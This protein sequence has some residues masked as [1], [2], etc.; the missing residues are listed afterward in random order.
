MDVC[1]FLTEGFETI[2]AFA[3][4]DI[5]R[6]A[7]IKTST[8]SITGNICVTSAQGVKVEADS[9]FD[10]YEFDGSELL[11]L[12]GGP[13]HKSYYQCE[14]LLELIKRYNDKNNRIAAICAAPSVLGNLGLLEGRKAMAFPGFEEQLK[15]AEV[16]M[17]PERVVTDGNI[18]TSRGMGTSID[19][20]LELVRLIKGQELSDKLRKST[21][22]V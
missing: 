15:G 14:K 13:G 4:L 19:L 2:E 10:E 6:R 22:Y 16:I 18:T 20:G 1:V 3:V 12:P 8:I 5:L 11:F 9:L 7:D 21:Q 17:A